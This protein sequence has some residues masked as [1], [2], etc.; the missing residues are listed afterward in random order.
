MKRFLQFGAFPQKILFHIFF[1]RL[2]LFLSRRELLRR[3]FSLALQHLSRFFLTFSHLR[4]FFLFLCNLFVERFLQLC[5]LLLEFF[6]HRL[7]L[8]FELL[9]SR[10][11]LLHRL[12]NL[13]FSFFRG[14]RCFFL[15]FRNV[16]V[17]CFFFRVEITFFRGDIAKYFLVLFFHF[18]HAR[19]EFLH[20]LL[21]FF[22]LCL[23]KIQL[24]FEL[25]P[26]LLQFF[27]FIRLQLLDLRILFMNFVLF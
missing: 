16:L 11:Y 27:N 23:A 13:F 14:L 25:R 5:L 7:L 1:L 17:E 21:S 8:G 9:S 4:H 15:S 26:S 6:C 10:R 18:F 2:E 3:I 12:G 19:L 24:F 20:Q 22:H